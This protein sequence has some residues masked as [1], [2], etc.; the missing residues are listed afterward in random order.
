MDT[1]INAYFA[2]VEAA[3]ANVA[4]AKS[5]LDT[6]T[7]RLEAKKKEVG[8]EEPKSN[9]TEKVAPES[10]EATDPPKNSKASKK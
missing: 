6:A 5:E 4:K 1:H 3:E 10:E 8:Y 7:A 9:A 2:D